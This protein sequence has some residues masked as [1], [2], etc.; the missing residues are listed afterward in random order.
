[1]NIHKIKFFPKIYRKQEISIITDLNS[2][3]RLIN[4]N[5]FLKVHKTSQLKNHLIKISNSKK[6]CMKRLKI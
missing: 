4:L 5:L 1:M 2:I 3:L 6:K